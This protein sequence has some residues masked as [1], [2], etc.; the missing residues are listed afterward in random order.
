MYYRWETEEE[1]ARRLFPGDFITEDEEDWCFRCDNH[2][3]RC[4]E[5][6]EEE[7]LREQKWEMSY[8]SCEAL[9]EDPEHTPEARQ[10]K[11]GKE[12]ELFETENE[13]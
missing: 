10:A 3:C 5:R 1:E 8:L 12:Q 4:L 9:E 13:N 7:R 11:W 6:E 2:N